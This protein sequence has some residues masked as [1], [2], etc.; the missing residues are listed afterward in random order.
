[1]TLRKRLASWKDG[2]LPKLWEEARAA[3]DSPKGPS[4]PITRSQSALDASN[5]L[6]TKNISLIKDLV[7]E[8]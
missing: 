7:S 1:M 8:G 2:Y 6:P 4:G 3:A 5:E